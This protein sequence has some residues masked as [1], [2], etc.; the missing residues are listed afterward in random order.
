M[1]CFNNVIVIDHDGLFIYIDAGYARSFHDVRCLRLSELFRNWRQCFRNENRDE[2][3]E[4][5]LGDTGY[6]GADM[7][8]LRRVDN[9]K[10]DAAN[11]VV[12]AFNKRHPAK[13][14]QVE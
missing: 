8:I 14:V 5:L 9:R 4:C 11:P 7:F 1:H 12:R 6:M 3:E 2:V 13:C 10:A